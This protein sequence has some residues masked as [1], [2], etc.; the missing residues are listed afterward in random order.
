M[1]SLPSGLLSALHKAITKSGYTNGVIGCNFSYWKKDVVAVNGYNNDIIGWGHEDSELGARLINN[2][3]AK[4]NLK[5]KAICFHLFHA[6]F[7]RER[8]ALNKQMLDKTIADKIVQC[9]MGTVMS[10]PVDSL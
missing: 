8:D 4:R 10:H 2:G 6:H 9:V 3:I 7:S 1:N 5:Y